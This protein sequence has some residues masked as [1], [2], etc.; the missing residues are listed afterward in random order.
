MRRRSSDGP[1]LAGGQKRRI[2]GLALPRFLLRL[3]Y[4]KDS[5]PV[6]EFDFEEMPVGSDHDGNLWGNPAIACV[7]ICWPSRS[8]VAAGTSTRAAS[9]DRGPAAKVKREEFQAW[10]SVVSDWGGAGLPDT[11]LT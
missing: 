9:G 2:L 3:P 5:S 10:H 4:G 7:V 1:A 8:S 6:E 11:L